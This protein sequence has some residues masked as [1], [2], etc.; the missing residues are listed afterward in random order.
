MKS[1]KQQTK[2]NFSP[3]LYHRYVMKNIRQEMAYQGEDVKTWQRRLRRKLRQLVGPFPQ[4]KTDLN[5]RHLWKQEHKFGTIEK[6]VFTSEP[7]ADVPAY[8]CLPHGASGKSPFMICL[9]GHTTGMHNSIAVEQKNEKQPL[10]VPGDRDFAIGCL[11][12]GVG[13]LCLEQRSFGERCERHQQVISPHG[14]HDAA[15][16]SFHLGSTLIGERVYDVDRAIDYLYT[17]DDV[18]TKRIGVMGNSGG[19][20]ISIYAAAL[21]RRVCLAVPSCS[22][23]TFAASILSIYHCADNY[24][25]G[26]YRY[27]DMADVMGLFAPKPVIVVAGLKDGIFPI[28]GVRK[29]FTHLKRIYK[30]AGYADRCH[31]VIGKSGHRFYAKESWPRILTEFKKIE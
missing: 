7:F 10:K 17:R 30:A 23:C 13:A 25:P 6:V 24:V 26:L 29:A 18:D 8:V 5:V 27:A 14:C 15:M 31:L 9:Q 1:Y 4:Q 21:L 22:F 16:R 28:N 11:K 12:R 20:T 2:F 3:S 19:G